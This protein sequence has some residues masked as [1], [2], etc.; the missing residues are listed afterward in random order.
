LLNTRDTKALCRRHLLGRAVHTPD[1]AVTRLP[2]YV[3]QGTVA[4]AQIQDGGLPVGGKCRRINFRKNGTRG[5]SPSSVSGARD[6]CRAL[7]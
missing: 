6:F 3:D 2:G 4:A 7:T 5:F 1:V